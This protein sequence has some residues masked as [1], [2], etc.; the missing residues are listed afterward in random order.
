MR[1]EKYKDNKGFTTTDIVLAIIIIILFVSIITTAYYN[2]YISSQSKSRKTIATNIVI[3][4]IENV[5]MLV[6]DEVNIN[7]VNELIESLKENGTIQKEY[8]VTSTLQNY[9]EISG[10]EDKKDL[11]KILKVKV[12]YPVGNKKEN[13]E[14]TRLI[15]KD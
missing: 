14:I 2:Y 9:N 12:E 15:T 3:D 7:S 4:V 10:N 1:V 6:Y 11:I 13:L 5:E 8:T